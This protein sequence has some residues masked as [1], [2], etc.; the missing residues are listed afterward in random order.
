MG[1]TGGMAF[2]GANAIASGYANSIS[3]RSQAE[4]QQAQYEQNQKLAESSA[5]DAR[6]RGDRN[7]SISRQQTRMNIGAQRAAAAASGV[8]VNAGSALDLQADT[9]GQGAMN[10]LTIKNNAWREAWGFKVQAANAGS[11]AAMAG[12]AGANASRNSLLTGGMNAINYGI[13]AAGSYAANN[14]WGGG[15]GGSITSGDAYSNTGS[16]FGDYS[17]MG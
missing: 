4:F 3:A 11:S 14:S 12:N 13:R 7:A 9:A 10:E 1:A 8:D 2:G 16:S 15:G 5:E 6:L 17:N